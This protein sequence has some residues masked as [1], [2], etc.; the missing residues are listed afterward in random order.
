M[1]E[2]QVVN[3]VSVVEIHLS[4]G[5]SNPEFIYSLRPLRSLR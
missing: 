5:A 1:T 3:G 2:L 4:F